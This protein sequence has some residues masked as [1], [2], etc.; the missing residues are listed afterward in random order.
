M[1]Y[2]NE[3]TSNTCAGSGN[4]SYF[5][6]EDPARVQVGRVFYK[7]FSGG[8]F[9]W[10]ILFS[11]II[12]STFSDGSW[13]HKNLVVDEWEIVSARIGH[14]R[15]MDGVELDPEQSFDI[16]ETGDIRVSDFVPLTFDGATSKTVRP[17]EFFS[18]DPVTLTFAKDEFLCL[19][20]SFRG[21]M[22][23]FHPESSIAS[24]KQ[25]D[26]GRWKICKEVPF[27]GMV[28]CDR[29]IRHRVAFLGDSITQG[30][31]TVY[32]AYEQW[33]AVLAGMLGEQDAYWNLGLGFGRADDAASDGAWLYKAKQNDAVVVCYGVNDMHKGY[34]EA[35]IRHNLTEIVDKLHA[36]GV[37]VMVQTIPP[38]DYSEPITQV[39]KNLNRFILEELSVKAD[40][41]FDV[42]PILGQGG[43]VSHRSRY[44]GHPNGFGCR[45]WAEALYPAMKEFIERL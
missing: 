33:N 22:I 32:N 26:A 16:S 17:A 40:A 23:P 14:C 21:G 45:V 38:F 39:W 31:G 42:V 30:C 34:T 13:S 29:P 11:N 27:A 8:T 19:E 18:S 44:G 6:P 28:G 37:R 3:F 35:Q 10:S 36:A 24:F 5:L 41:V 25:D 15:S 7:V 43:E 4:Q 2:F 20:V 12:D 1:R 9:R